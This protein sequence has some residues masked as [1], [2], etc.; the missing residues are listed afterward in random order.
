M[1]ICLKPRQIPMFSLVYLN[2]R[3]CCYI[4]EEGFLWT[5]I[6]SYLGIKCM[7]SGFWLCISQLFSPQI[8]STEQFCTNHSTS[9]PGTALLRAYESL[10]INAL[11]KALCKWPSTL[12]PISKMICPLLFRHSFEYYS[13]SQIVANFV[14]WDLFP[15]ASSTPFTNV[16][17]CI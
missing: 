9:L 1:Y 14:I 6:F 3:A 10:A 8:L 12:Q 2:V 15:A 11:G 5:E 16:L 7:L 17:W 4:H 13:S